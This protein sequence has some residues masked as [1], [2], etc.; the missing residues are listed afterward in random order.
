MFAP[1]TREFVQ[2]ESLQAELVQER[3]H[4]RRAERFYVEVGEKAGLDGWEAGGLAFRAFCEGWGDSCH[5]GKAPALPQ[6]TRKGWGTRNLTVEMPRSPSYCKQTRGPSTAQNRSLRE[7]FCSARDDSA[8][9]T[10]AK[11][12]CQSWG[13]GCLLVFS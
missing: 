13:R 11:N 8:K 5:L 12:R 9:V 7:R 4:V 3:L 2:W 6:R 10:T 1:W